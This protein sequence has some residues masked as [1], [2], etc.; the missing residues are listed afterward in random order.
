MR[1]TFRFEAPRQP[2][3][4]AV[5]AIMKKKNRVISTVL[6]FSLCTAVWPAKVLAQE[7]NQAAQEKEVCIRNLKQIYE[8]IQAYRR[9]HKELPNWLSDL[10]PNYLKDK[11]VLTCPTSSRTGRIENFG[12][13]DPKLPAVSYIYEFCDAEMGK[14]YD[15]GRVKMREWKRRQM[16]LVGSAVPMVRCHLHS[17]VLNLSFDGKVYESP[18]TWEGVFND[19][20]NMDDLMPNRLFGQIPDQLVLGLSIARTAARA[21]SPASKGSDPTQRPLDLSPFYNAMLTVAWHPKPADGGPGFDLAA[22]PQKI[23]TLAGVSFDIRGIIQLSGQK[24]KAAGGEFPEAV[25]GI[26]V[27]AKCRRLH[28]LH[29]VGWSAADGAQVGLYRLHYA[30]GRAQE[31]PIIYGKQVRDWFSNPG[32]QPLGDGTVVAWSVTPPR[33]ADNKTLFKTSWDNPLPDVE[34][35]SIDAV[36]SMADPAPFLIAISVE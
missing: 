25:K 6:A 27:G 28:F 20:V 12:L 13:G 3:H 9:D 7:A 22:L 32:S 18:D 23:Q 30:D 26:P 24:L 35:K 31:L 2:D 4:N 10:V 8:A 5:N 17:P 21:Q 34:L 14:I 16:G 19:V 11:S 36:S 29:S 33:D 15:G 1:R